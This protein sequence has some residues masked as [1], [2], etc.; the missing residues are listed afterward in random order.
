M[1]EF[2]WESLEEVFDELSPL[3]NAHYK[4][5]Y[6]SDVAVEKENLLDLAAGGGMFLLVSRVE[7]YP[8]G[9][10]ATVVCPTIYNSTE[11]EVKEIGIYTDPAY[12]GKGITTTSQSKMDSAL[13]EMG[14]NSVLVSYPKQTTIPLRAGYTVKQTIFERRL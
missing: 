12:R 1:V 13:K 4:E 9:Y 7:G 5:I 8:V 10:Y 6:N 2:A 14:A 3:F 11:V